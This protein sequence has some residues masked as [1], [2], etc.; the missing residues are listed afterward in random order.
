MIRLDNDA[1]IHKEDPGE[2]GYEGKPKRISVTKQE[3]QLL[4]MAAIGKMVAEIGTGLGVATR[5]MSVVARR[6]YTCDVDPWVISEIVPT[7]PEY[8]CFVSRE[9]LGVRVAGAFDMVFIDGLHT[10]DAVF[11]DIALACAAVR[12]GG[13]VI[14]H[15][16]K[17]DSVQAAIK[18]SEL[19][20]LAEFD[21]HYGLGVYVPRK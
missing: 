18:E 13:Q 1:F 5:V 19:R 4:A 2:P 17:M 3:A 7:L 8:V 14:I 9:F 6:V 10:Q 11:A 20:M 15:D 21:T 12:Q 16:T